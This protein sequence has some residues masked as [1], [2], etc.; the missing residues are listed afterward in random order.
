MSKIALGA[1]LDGPETEVS[2]STKAIRVSITSK[3]LIPG[4]VE[5]AFD[6]RGC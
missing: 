5:G 4:L 6:L 2:P 3:P 1:L